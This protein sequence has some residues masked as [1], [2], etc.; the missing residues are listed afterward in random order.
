VAGLLV[1]PQSGELRPGRPHWVAPT[2]AWPYS[3]GHGWL[4]NRTGT[5]IVRFAALLVHAPRDHVIENDYALC[6]VQLALISESILISDVRRGMDVSTF[7]LLW[8]I[9]VYWRR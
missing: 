6:K 4:A 2:D 9:W 3:P 1:Y 5:G 8:A 7:V